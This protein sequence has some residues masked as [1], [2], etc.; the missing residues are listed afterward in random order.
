MII[1]SVK[2]TVCYHP[3]AHRGQ[4]AHFAVSVILPYAETVPDGGRQG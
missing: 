4:V 3:L 2:V 1:L